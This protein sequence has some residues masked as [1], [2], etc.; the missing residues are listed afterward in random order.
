MELR[1]LRYF[2]EIAGERS[3]SKAAK[4]LGVSQPTLSRQ[5]SALEQEFGHELYTRN[6]EGIQLTE[7]G[8]V[9][10]RNAQTLVALADRTEQE[11]SLPAN[12][13]AGTVRIGAGDTHAM[14]LL[15]DAVNLVRKSYPNVVF[16]FFSGTSAFLLDGLERGI[17]DLALDCEPRAYN[18][19][20]E[21]QLPIADTWCAIMRADDPLA[22]KRSVSP[23]DLRSRKLILPQR[24]ESLSGLGQ[25]LNVGKLSD[26]AVARFSLPLNLRYLVNAKVGIALTYDDL[27]ASEDDTDIC[28]RPLSP[29]VVSRHSVL[30]PRMLPNRQTEVFLRALREVCE[31]Y[32]G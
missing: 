25:W 7:Y 23:D 28:S 17:Y 30:W 9:L 13:I 21:M 1:A 29:K 11:M 5:L 15:A 16:H 10:Q 2:L 19:M 12:S 22:S 4:K 31:R 20:N 26:N 18:N 24:C 6:Y 32:S 14:Q 27:I 8:I 3:I